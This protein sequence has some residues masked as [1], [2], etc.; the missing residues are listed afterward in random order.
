M[1]SKQDFTRHF[2]AEQGI[3]NLGGIE[4]LVR[5][6]MDQIRFDKR[7]GL[8]TGM[9]ISGY[10]GSPVGMLDANLAKQQKLLLQHN[11][12]FVDGLNE[13]LGATAVWGTQML[14]TVGRQKFDG[15]LGMWYAKAPGVDRSG[16][17]LK[18]A[19]YT[20]IAKNG[21]V[22]AI[23]GDDPSCKSSSL[24]SQSEAM[25]YHVGI[26]SLYP[27]DIQDILDFGLH[28][29]YL[30]RISGLWCGMKIVTNVADG[31]G[32]A[33]VDPD[34]MNF[35]TPVV[36]LDGKPYVPEVNLGMNVRKDALDMERTLYYARLEMAR[37]YAR[38]NNLNKVTL[39]NPDAWLGIVTAGKT[40]HDMRQAFMEMGLDD[41]ALRRAGVRILKIG[42]L[43][44]LQPDDV[45]D[46]ARGLEEILVIEEKRPFIELFAKEALYGMSN[47]PRIVGKKDEEGR[48]LLPSYSE[49]ESDTIIRALHARLSRKMKLETAE[50]WLKRLDEIHSRSSLT[51]LTRSA[52]YCSGCPHNSSTKAPDGSIVSAG[53]GCH[54][55]AMWMNRG[56]VMGT[57]MGA[58]GT[59]WIGMQPFTET[60]HIFQNMGDGTYAHSGSLAVRYAAATN[61][62]ITFKI[63][64]NKHTSMTGGQEIIGGNP[65]V[66]MVSEVLANG[67]KKVIVTT[68]ELGRYNGVQLP[69]GTEVWH[70]DRL[71]EA[72]KTL[73]AIEGTTVLIHDQECAAELRRQRGRGK[74]FEPEQRMVINERVCEGCGDCGVKSNCMSV[75]PVQTEF[76]RKTRIHQPSC[77]KDYSCVK[78]FCPSFLT[79][80]P[81]AAPEGEGKKKKGRLPALDRELPDPV[82]KVDANNFGAHIMGIG[83][84]GS[85]TVAAT[86]ANAARIDG[87][88]A[89]GLDQTGLAQKG[90]T[91]ISDI[92]VTT[93]QFDGSN[94]ISDGCTDLYLGFDILNATDNKNLDKCHPERTIAIVSTGQAA[95][96]Y[97]VSDKNVRFPNTDGLVRG[98]DRV[99]RKADNVYMDA[100][101]MAEGLF[102]DSMA[103]NMFMVGVAYQ[104]GAL[105][106]SAASI[107]AAIKQ[108]GVG[109]EMSMLA[110]KWGRMAVHDLDFVKAEIKKYEAHPAKVAVLSAEARQIA[111]SVGASGEVKRIVEIRVADLIEYQ[112]AD[113][114]RRYAAKIKSV[115]ETEKR[116]SPESTALSEAAARYFY[117]LMAYKDEYEVGRLHSSPEF[118]AELEAMFPNGYSIEYNLAPPMFSKRDPE[119]GELIKKKYGPWVLKAF[120]YLA[121]MKGLRGGALDIFGKTEERRQERQ[122]IEDYSRLLDEI[123]GKLSRDNH[124]VAV[125][126]ASVPDQIRGYGHIKEKNVH[127]AKAAEQKLLEAFRNPTGIRSAA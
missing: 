65:L 95:T 31:S 109:V 97:M 90:G 33:I 3:I 69:G 19:N 93:K 29:Y 25:F 59:Q 20:G 49:F 84:T 106:I 47:A 16:D 79:V 22:L 21:G 87:K 9:F 127:L 75:E 15:V 98:I 80:T 27:G 10:R 8:N 13:D 68:E 118:K 45:K 35:V 108:A 58:E 54:T 101:T 51:S 125:E 120:G 1:S 4:A 119:T 24:P 74:A 114:A 94:K 104:A 86:I 85:V 105:P 7:R 6:P 102:A 122:A 34:R 81:N 82:F 14:H 61:A 103:T 88:W 66:N 110:F 107:E 62:N 18:H 113:Y 71:M 50:G 99:T 43:N 26:P 123:V 41:E 76:G 89:M 91:V 72:Q 64:F 63:L 96:G 126:L 57:H 121:R 2:T 92:K 124:A 111:D 17:V 40:Y 78:G 83:G 12:H 36:E 77:N 23:F 5:L 116:V 11:I 37:L 70:R 112:D 73:A 56:V 38:A 60:K 39:P 28:G 44:P 55:M 46:F 53:I 117:K 48:D 30:S 115:I 67:V 42:M 32:S 52:W 100:Q